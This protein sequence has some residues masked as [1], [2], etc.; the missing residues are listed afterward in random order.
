MKKLDLK[1]AL[2]SS[3][4]VYAIGITLFIS[5]FSFSLMDDPELQANLVLSIAIIPAAILAAKFYYKRNPETNGF[6]LGAFM[7]LGAMILDALI[8][9]P[10]FIIPTGGNHLSFFTDPGFWMIAVIYIATVWGYSK[11]HSIRLR[12]RHRKVSW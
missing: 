8:T 5:S 9:V 6:K 3:L 11:V 7:F 4:I 2:L 10:V 12:K 1:R